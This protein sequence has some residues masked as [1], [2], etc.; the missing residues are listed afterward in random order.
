MRFSY[1]HAG[2]EC[3]C[4]HILHQITSIM[5]VATFELTEALHGLV[6]WQRVVVDDRS[7][8]ELVD[9]DFDLFGHSVILGQ[10]APLQAAIRK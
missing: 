4:S 1:L 8:S 2:G 5:G 10:G 3:Q 7:A 9:K 6:D